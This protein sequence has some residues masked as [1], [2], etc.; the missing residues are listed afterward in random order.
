MNKLRLKIDKEK[1]LLA[2]LFVN[3]DL[4]TDI[5]EK[6]PLDMISEIHYE[7]FKAISEPKEID[8]A[9][10]LWLL[11]KYDYPNVKEVLELS[12]SITPNYSLR[13][14]E[15]YDLYDSI[16][17]DIFLSDSFEKSK[18]TILGLDVL[19]E[20]KENI[21]REL[22]KYS[23]FDFVSTFDKS[24]DE[25]IERIELRIK[26][27]R[28]IKTISYPSFNTATGGLNGGNLVGIAGAY[29]NGKTTFAMNIILDLINQG[30]SS[31]IFSLE[32]SKSEVEDKVLACKVGISY[33][34]IR[35]PNRLTNDE[36]RTLLKFKKD[37]SKTNEKLF[38]HD[39]VLSITEI[40]NVI[41]KLKSK[42][43]LQVVMLDYIGLVKS[44][45]RFRNTET[46]ERE[47][48]M[49]SNSLK[50]LAKE[51]DT[52]I[53]VLSQLNRNGIKEASSFNLAESLALARDCDF[54]FTIFKP[55]NSGCD[56]INIEGKEIMIS[57]NDFVVKLDSSRHSV[58]G[59]Q[60]LLKLEESGRMKETE[61]RYDNS[62]L[63][64][65]GMPTS[66]YELDDK[67]F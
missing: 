30:I 58:S 18:N 63:K 6:I 29:K 57:E 13:I 1:E 36:I 45:S 15:F 64:R 9:G 65:E 32:M 50:L 56:R 52:I 25:V 26:N 17:A 37:Y 16:K 59:K 24:L 28:A 43:G 27:D 5:F 62:Y 35:N 7:L 3:P 44:I 60:F 54:L 10:V 55:E 23:R 42:F 46:R 61:T 22:S 11:K 12:T 2:L 66:F 8:Q 19:S 53:F 20:L 31:A 39:R 38:I 47:I 14:T 49:I 48:S 67:I 51:T 40:E 4:R 34:K 21:D 33:E 41:R